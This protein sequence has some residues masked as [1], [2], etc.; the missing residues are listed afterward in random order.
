MEEEDEAPWAL[1]Q[2]FMVLRFV[3]TKKRICV[4]KNPVVVC[5]SPL[6]KGELG[7]VTGIGGISW[8]YMELLDVTGTFF[9]G[10]QPPAEV[11]SAVRVFASVFRRFGGPWDACRYAVC[12]QLEWLGHRVTL[13]TITTYHNRCCMFRRIRSSGRFWHFLSFSGML[14]TLQKLWTTRMQQDEGSGNTNTTWD[15]E[16]LIRIVSSTFFDT[17][18]S[19]QALCTCAGHGRT[20]RPMLPWDLATAPEATLIN[21]A[22]LHH[23]DFGMDW[24]DFVW[25]CSAWS[26][27]VTYSPFAPY[28]VAHW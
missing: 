3:S 6:L 22:P 24:L 18:D 10:R 23:I 27:L 9:A 14:A 26:L 1:T 28:D 12:E 5:L 4:R 16:N 11:D 8:S 25:F 2:L 19:H 7:D 15:L 20:C 21:P 17:F 13:K